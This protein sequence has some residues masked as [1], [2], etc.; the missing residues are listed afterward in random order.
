MVGNTGQGAGGGKV[1]GL[2]TMGAG[3]TDFAATGRNGLRGIGLW[4]PKGSR[5]SYVRGFNIA[6]T[7]H[8]GRTFCF[9]TRPASEQLPD[10]G[11]DTQAARV[12]AL[13]PNRLRSSMR[14][15]ADPAQSFTNQLAEPHVPSNARTTIRSA[16]H[17]M[18]TNA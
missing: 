16:R 17:V 11:E 8:I 3:A 4:W 2:A 15:R 10:L 14:L 7:F 12:V 13:S 1:V 18:P 6:V 5:P 9:S